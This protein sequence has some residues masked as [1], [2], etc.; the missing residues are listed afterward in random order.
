MNRSAPSQRSDFQPT[1]E[2]VQAPPTPEQQQQ[3]HHRQQSGTEFKPPTEIRRSQIRSSVQSSISN[4]HPE[5][6]HQ[7][8][9]GIIGPEF[10]PPP[11]EIRRSLYR[12]SVKSSISAT[13]FS[14]ADIT[15]QV[16][17]RASTSTGGATS[18]ADISLAEISS[19]RKG[20]L[21]T[22]GPSDGVISLA[23]FRNSQTSAPYGHRL[24]VGLSEESI[25]E[26]W[27]DD[28]A[29]NGGDGKG[30]HKKRPSS[31]ARAEVQAVAQR[32]IWGV[33]L[34]KGAFLILAIA[35]AALV[36]AGTMVVLKAQED[37]D[38]EQSYDHLTNSMTDVVQ[39][40]VESIYVSFESLANLLSA[41]AASTGARF[42][43]H[44]MNNFE[45]AGESFRQL[46]RA[47]T[48]SWI[49]IVEEPNEQ[50]WINYSNANQAWLES[51]RQWALRSSVTNVT[52]AEYQSGDITRIIYDL[53]G[54]NGTP[55]PSLSGPPHAPLWMTSPPVVN[56]KSINMD[57]QFLEFASTGYQALQQLR[58]AIFSRI[59]APSESGLVTNLIWNPDGSAASQTGSDETDDDESLQEAR[60]AFLQ[61]VFSDA[62]D[63]SSNLVGF[64]SVGL[65][66]DVYLTNLLPEGVV[67]LY[68]VVKNTC[69]Q[70]LTYRLSGNR[71]YLEGWDD[72]HD[73]A[74]DST[75]YVVPFNR[76][77]PEGYEA[78]TG[79]CIFSLHIFSSS[80]FED[81]YRST[82]AVIL[83]CV[84]LGAFAFLIAS[85]LMYDWF[86]RRRN[87]KVLDVATKSS[88]LVSSLFPKTVR[89]RLYQ[90]K[91]ATERG[92]DSANFMIHHAQLNVLKE[93]NE[94]SIGEMLEGEQTDRGSVTMDDDG[95]MYKSTP[96]ADRYPDA[97]VI[98]ADVVGFT[99]WSSSRDPTEVFTLLETLYK[100]FDTIAK[101]RRVFKVE[102]IGDC[103]VAVAGLP[104]PMKEHAVT[105]CRFAKDIISKTHQLTRKL[106]A[107]LGPDTR[108]L[109]L[110]VG[111]HSGP[112]TAG[113]LRGD[114]SRF[115]LFGDTM[116]TGEFVFSVP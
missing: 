114:K 23:D 76:P 20:S 47:E 77:L 2:I 10:E 105:M 15:P 36:S 85:F 16:F 90:E 94:K 86:V 6:F 96:I 66:W 9:Q 57:F 38:Y 62:Q 14:Y 18:Q 88:E 12:S 98:F 70:S 109:S 54:P 89:D 100:A 44:T 102:T 21:S 59:L 46:S 91:E 28:H 17:R 41:D 45:A 111:L 13:A 25:N 50:Q 42:P 35:I 71:A 99:A 53:G 3:H 64:F 67:G 29:R 101:R 72:L 37:E 83:M 97:T 58:T 34:W 56:P 63:S 55:R 65:A 48:I 116:N 92:T 22:R 106:E 115:Q 73:R 19:N 4:V 32:E 52:T 78:P 11:G 104:E 24:N 82:T 61:P 49:P 8:Q 107:I 103:Y 31:E 1:L 84:V 80:E 93:E 27:S 74:Y 81:S 33:R 87:T 26:F 68:C 79:Q 39:S 75:E 40:H 51:S 5:A 43:F 69:G 95:F 30:N 113:V 110:R 108:D 60:G 7:E 112:V